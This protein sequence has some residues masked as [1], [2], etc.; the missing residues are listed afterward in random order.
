MVLFITNLNAGQS[1]EFGILNENAYIQANFPVYV[2][3]LSGI[4]CELGAAILPQIKCSGSSNVSFVR[5]TDLDVYITLVVQKDGLN[6]FFINGQAANI[7]VNQFTVVQGTRNMWYTAKVKLDSIRF[8]KA[9]IIT[10]L[11]TSHFFHLGVLQGSFL[12][13]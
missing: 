13:E 9:S 1:Y 7:N 12:M 2:Y 6:N 3:Q 10:V 5:S 8:P 4:G 11:N